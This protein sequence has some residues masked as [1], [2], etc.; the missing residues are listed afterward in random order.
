MATGRRS[1]QAVSQQKYHFVVVAAVV[2]VV[3]VDD[4]VVNSVADVVVAVVVDP[5]KTFMGVIGYEVIPTKGMNNF[6][7]LPFEASHYYESI[8]QWSETAMNVREW[9]FDKKL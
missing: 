3:V 4:V 5:T 8:L 2:V 6:F 7:S 1:P 9:K